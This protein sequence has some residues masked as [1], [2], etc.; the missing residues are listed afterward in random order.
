MIYDNFENISLYCQKSSKLYR[1][2]KFA[3]DF[4]LSQPDGEY[5]VE[6]RDIFAKVQSYT[7]QKAE[8]RVFE[9]HRKYYDIQVMRLGSEHQDVYVGKETEFKSLTEYNKQKDVIK[10]ESPQLFS[11]IIV[12]PG[13]F[14][15]YYPNDIH[16]PNCCIHA[17][18]NVRKICM[19][20]KL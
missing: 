4:N 13:K 6:G 14:A 8:Q 2:I 18:A 7:T 9:A 16:R 3:R 12:S 17:P 10:L 15:V 20:V 5:E 11:S 19:K 1:A